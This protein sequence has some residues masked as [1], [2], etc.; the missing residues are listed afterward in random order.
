M[1]PHAIE[2][3]QFVTELQRTLPRS[4]QEAVI[5]GM[6]KAGHPLSKAQ[7]AALTQAIGVGTAQA[8]NIARQKMEQETFGQKRRRLARAAFV[9]SVYATTDAGAFFVDVP[10]AAALVELARTF[11]IHKVRPV[12]KSTSYPSGARSTMPCQA[13]EVAEQL[14]DRV[15]AYYL[16]TANTSGERFAV[17]RWTTGTQEFVSLTDEQT[18]LSDDDKEWYNTLIRTVD[19]LK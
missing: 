19:T 18:I 10:D 13:D 6:Q 17:W 8:N 15:T 9:K 14:D 3:R 11:D 16:L 4:I 1:D 7:I 5:G 2:D 12:Y